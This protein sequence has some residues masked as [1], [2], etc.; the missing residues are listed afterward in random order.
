M[1]KE[2]DLEK[3]EESNES[4]EE[5]V[6][7][8]LQ[9]VEMPKCFQEAIGLPGFALGH[10]AM[11][12][13]LSDSGKT[14]VL[15]K[16]AREASKQDILPIIIITENKLDKT[17]LE[18]MGL[19]HKKNCLIKEDL[20]TLEDVFDYISM[21]V[22]DIKNGKLRKN[23]FIFWDSVAGTPSKES[24]TVE[25]DGKITK[26]YG[27]QKNASVIG[28]YN[29]IIAKRVASTREMNSDFSLGVLMLNQAYKNM[30]EFPGAP[31]TTVPNGGEKIWFPISLAIEI[32]EGKRIKT[33]VD[34]RDL[35]IGLVSK[36]KVKKNHVTGI[37]ASGEV[38]LAGS[39]MFEND[40]KLIKEYKEKFKENK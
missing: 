27:P 31:V 19:E 6:Y 7:K 34:G 33:T 11:I 26:K 20:T 13:G 5:I 10:T 32:K 1:T 18:L 12:Y 14:D 3:Y 15:L 2:F 21:K 40:E 30:P 24:F 9:Y 23:C 8:P 39:E 36:L 38:V 25:K 4:T 29:P 35:E 17:R 28:Y 22:E 37:N 16:A